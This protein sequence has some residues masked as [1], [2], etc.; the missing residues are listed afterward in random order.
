M[1]RMFVRSVV[2]TPMGSSIEAL[3]DGRYRVCDAS[4]HC[5]EVR[6]LWSAGEFVREMEVH[7]RFPDP[8][9]LSR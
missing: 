2:S 4:H 9:P 3:G 5:A 6:G 8:E 7:H 1:R